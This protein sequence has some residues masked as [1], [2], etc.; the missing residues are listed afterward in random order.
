M[1]ISGTLLSKM[2]GHFTRKPFILFKRL[3]GTEKQERKSTIKLK[4]DLWTKQF[5]II[6]V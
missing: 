4:T 2:S 1:S 5:G 3:L 6:N